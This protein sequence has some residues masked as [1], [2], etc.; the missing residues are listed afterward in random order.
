MA[1]RKEVRRQEEEG[2]LGFISLEVSR[3]LR[4]GKSYKGGNRTLDSSEKKPG[5]DPGSET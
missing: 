1:L 4:G 3:F 2:A 5:R